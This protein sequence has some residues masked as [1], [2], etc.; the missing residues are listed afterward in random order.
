MAQLIQKTKLF[1]P[2]ARPNLVDRPRLLGMLDRLHAAG[3]R[4]MLVSAPAGS[5]KT[6][7]LSQWLSRTGWAVG[8][9]S[10][11]ARD[12]LPARFF[13][14]LIAAL[15]NI[16]PETGRQAL[17]LLDLPRANFEEVITLL[18]NDLVDIPRPFVLALDDYHTITH[19]QIHQAVDRLIEAQPP[20]MRLVLLS[21]EDPPLP[22]AR[23]RARGQLIEVRQEDLRFSPQ[24][25]QAFLQQ[26]MALNLSSQQ[27]DL[28]ETR[29]EGWIAGLQ[30]AA[31]SLQ[32]T[33]DV[34][35]FLQDF[36]GSHRFILDYLLEEVLAHQ[37]NEVQSFLFE[38]AFLER[39]CADLC[40]Y[41]TE[42]STAEVQ[43]LLEQFIRAN[44]FVIPLDEEQEWFR[45]HHL[46]RDLLLARMQAT[47][48]ARL[49]LLEQRASDWYEAHGDFHLSVEYALKA[50][51]MNRAADRIDLH[52]T[53][54]W[55]TVDLDFHLLLNRL[56]AEVIAERPSLC[57]QS[58][59]LKVI[60]GQADQI[61]PLIEAAERALDRSD[62]QPQ[63]GDLANR[64]FARSLRMYLEDFFNRPVDL[65]DAALDQTLAVIP[66]QNP[67][68]YNSVAVV[69]GTIYFMEERFSAAQRCFE[70][71][72]QLDQQVNGTN[73]VP[74]ATMRTVF[75]DQVQGRL[76]E[77]MQL[78][79]QAN[80]Y[81]QAR[82][83]RRFYISGVLS[84]LMG[85]ILL[86]WNRL[87]E[88]EP[89][90]HEGQRLLE[91]WPIPAARDLGWSLLAR[92]K[93]ARGDLT[94]A[95]EV[96]DE[97]D[98]HQPKNY[99][100]IFLDAV[101]KARVRF[102]TATQDRAALE[103]WVAANDIPAHQTFR[104]RYEARQIECCRAWLALERPKEAAERLERLA[105]AAQTRRGSHVAILA[106]LAA[107]RAPEQAAAR[108]SEQAA[109]R[110]PEPT[111][112]LSA[113][114]EALRLAEP[115]GYLFTFVET[116]E[117][118][119]LILEQ[120]LKN[121]PESAP[122]RLCEYARRVLAGFHS[123]AA[124]P[125]NPVLLPEP[126]SPREQEVLR[127]VAQGLTNAQIA[128]H[129]VISVRTVKK[130][131]ENIHGKLDVQNRT[132]AVARAREIGLIQ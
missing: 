74:I 3:C 118:L 32:R 67:G 65:D 98:S 4:V 10:L 110:A 62:R 96:I 107:A 43:T 102:W 37:S 26:S 121:P 59:W 14:Y 129:L 33:P 17:A 103:A 50:G 44:L 122:Q 18:T 28:L 91:D 85:E 8:W 53:E 100:P 82:G 83:T 38:T 66:Q 9:L 77:A 1:L 15:Q 52:I 23:R 112:A 46:F 71:A 45:Y 51:D 12:N 97:I 24:E 22:M 72:I 7:L 61:L 41:V 126:L 60:F 40:A 106:L 56:P 114:D 21:R 90:I 108:A 117:P 127:L 49:I 86:E 58:A 48:P 111:A 81:I 70:K 88:A 99:H 125:Q 132:Q 115:E 93:I 104:F 13:T 123:P 6:T 131:V 57:L 19:P 54:Y 64:A 39:L 63:P 109:A 113:L 87:D 31:L 101:E 120:W 42:K 94:A 29:T 5:G 79:E 84:L 2:T 25:A 130:H 27:V 47:A 105:A 78:L 35:R 30:M 116:G 36:S 55:Q 119:R 128:D 80:H 92:L 69:I 34:E 11:D 16:A 124:A 73:A 68:M 75:I 89:L 76:H 20:Q 95:R